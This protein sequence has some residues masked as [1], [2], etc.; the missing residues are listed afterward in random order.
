MSVRKD[1]LF[2]KILEMSALELERFLRSA[3]LDNPILEHE[4]RSLTSMM[5]AREPELGRQE[6]LR[7]IAASYARPQ[8]LEEYL[9]EQIGSL[10]LTAVQE[11]T[12]HRM[13]DSLDEK[14]YL[15][16]DEPKFINR[17]KV[18]RDEYETCLAILQCMDPPGVGA[19]NIGECMCIQLRCKG[20]ID[21]L[22]EKIASEHL[23]K[24]SGKRPKTLAQE[25]GVASGE[26]ARVKALLETLNPIPAN[27]FAQRNFVRYHA[28]DLIVE[29]TAQG[30]VL[31]QNEAV[32]PSLIVNSQYGD[33]LNEYNSTLEEREFVLGKIEDAQLIYSCVE[34][35]QALMLACGQA[36]IKRQSA[37]LE[38][39]SAKLE[40]FTIN[41]IALEINKSPAIAMRAVKNKYLLCGRGILPLS[42]LIARSDDDQGYEKLAP[43]LKE[44]ID[45]ENK[46][47]PLSDQKISEKL[48]D[49][50]IFIA[51]RTVAKYRMKL[52][53]P[54][55]SNRK[56]T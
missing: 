48:A 44:L 17:L 19:R 55:A 22:A 24:L 30:Y 15:K 11:I 16:V 40:N 10:K 9:R 18:D 7:Q 46:K 45:N 6:T 34:Q 49:E 41:D 12:L 3:A 36:I 20:L 35:R 28:A 53:L 26:V 37:L 29:K 31:T 27:G 52:A 4:P 13:V 56:Q 39:A 42:E 5:A 54:N 43:R 21:P 50:G 38:N 25:L 14:G 47:T 1:K 33:V 32:Q 2:T 8:S 23:E 51:R